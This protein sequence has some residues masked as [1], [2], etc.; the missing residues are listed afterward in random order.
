MTVNMYV[1]PR[2]QKVTTEELN[3]GSNRK[4]LLLQSYCASFFY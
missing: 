4:L 2:K 3:F 1:A